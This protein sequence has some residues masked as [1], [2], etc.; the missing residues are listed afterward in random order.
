MPKYWFFILVLYYFFINYKKI[1][2]KYA[3]VI[4]NYQV[5]KKKMYFCSWWELLLQNVLVYDDY[6]LF[7]LRLYYWPNVVEIIRHVWYV[8]IFAYK[9]KN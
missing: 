6:N 3:N 9:K 5:F 4:M 7:C 2:S 1:Q 8:S